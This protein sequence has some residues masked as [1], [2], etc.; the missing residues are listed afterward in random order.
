M[1]VEL[2]AEA[3]EFLKKYDKPIELT[4]RRLDQNKHSL[5]G[6]Q[7]HINELAEIVLRFMNQYNY[8][9][10]DDEDDCCDDIEKVVDA[11]D[12]Q[13]TSGQL[14]YL[15]SCIASQLMKKKSEPKPHPPQDTTTSVRAKLNFKHLQGQAKQHVK[16]VKKQEVKQYPPRFT[17]SKPEPIVDITSTHKPKLNLSHIQQVHQPASVAPSEN[18][19]KSSLSMSSSVHRG[20][21]NKIDYSF[22]LVDGIEADN[23]I[24]NSELKSYREALKSINERKLISQLPK[25]TGVH[26]TNDARAVVGQLVKGRLTSWR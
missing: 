25:R 19:R 9:N 13:L 3:K 16:E 12:I 8:T 15:E 20:R 10:Y 4:L 24:Y 21:D 2:E 5:E 14:N 22:G 17:T 18:T 6:T 23:R 26:A 11:L 1:T 7:R